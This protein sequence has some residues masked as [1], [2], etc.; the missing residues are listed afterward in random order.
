MKFCIRK[1]A[2]LLQRSKKKM[3]SMAIHRFLPS[4]TWLP[5]VIAILLASIIYLSHSEK[6]LFYQINSV[7][8]Y[9]GADLWAN[10]TILGDSLIAAVLFIPWIRRNPDL[11]WAAIIGSIIALLISHGLKNLM[12]L[13]RPAGA[14]PLD[15]FNI[16][17]PV[18]KHRSFPSGHATTVFTFLGIWILSS[19]QLWS[20]WALLT[21]GMII[22]LSRIVVGV[23]WPTDILAGMAV[24][25]FSAIAGIR[26]IRYL[27]WG[28]KP[29]AHGAFIF[30]TILSAL[31]LLVRY[32]TGYHN[33]EL[34]Q[35]F[36]ALACLITFLSDLTL[37]LLKR[38]EEKLGVKFFVRS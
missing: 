32:K 13:P 12:H 24:G 16:I 27:P 2:S 10:L 1:E 14:L 38:V 35:S 26:S 28:L 29:A 19:R 9:T 11:V 31:L 7:S 8:Q 25:W 33:V 20:R 36:V 6:A 4:W 37:L 23:H 30:L 17:G 18:F 22:A 3:I 5:P 34:L 15:S 21:V